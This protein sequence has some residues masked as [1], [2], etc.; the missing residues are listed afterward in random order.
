MTDNSPV[1]VT[2]WTAGQLKEALSRVPDDL[3]VCVTPD[4]VFIDARLPEDA[5]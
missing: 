4:E 2:G 1:E 5:A 3:P